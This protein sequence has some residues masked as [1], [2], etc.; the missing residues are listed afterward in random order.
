[1][2]GGDTFN[3]VLLRA[4]AIGSGGEDETFSVGET[5][6]EVVVAQAFAMNMVSRVFVN[7]YQWEVPMKLPVD[8]TLPCAGG[9]G[10]DDSYGPGILCVHSQFRKQFFEVRL[11]SIINL[12]DNFSKWVERKDSQCHFK[13]QGGCLYYFGLSRRQL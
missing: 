12:A 4:P 11:I 10:E 7:V 13:T 1:M 5:L 8:C 9:T 3:P 2:G 6:L